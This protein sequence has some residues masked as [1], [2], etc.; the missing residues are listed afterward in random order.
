MAKNIRASHSKAILFMMAFLHEIGFQV[1]VQ[2][3]KSWLNGYAF[4]FEI[5]EEPCLVGVDRPI[6]RALKARPI[7]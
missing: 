5:M 2:V 3:K 4:G 7:I 1:H 6:F